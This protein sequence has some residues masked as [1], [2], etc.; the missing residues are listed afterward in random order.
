LNT[1]DS[2]ERTEENINFECIAFLCEGYTGSNLFDMCKKT[3]FFFSFRE[4]LDEENK[5]GEIVVSLL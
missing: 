3:A 4:L 2:T 5:G 1:L